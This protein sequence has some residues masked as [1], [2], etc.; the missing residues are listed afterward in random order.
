MAAQLNRVQAEDYIRKV[1]DE[2]RQQRRRLLA[3]DTPLSVLL[4]H[5]LGLPLSVKA[6]YIADRLLFALAV[7]SMHYHTSADLQAARPWLSGC[8]GYLFQ[9]E[10]PP[11]RS[12]YYLIKLTELPQDARMAFFDGYLPPSHPL[13]R[14]AD[15]LKLFRELEVICVMAISGVKKLP[16]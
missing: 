6:D 2:L 8:V 3:L 1:D 13:R 11:Q 7:G 14:D 16:M 5:L 4:Q 9:R 10:E 12:F 15:M